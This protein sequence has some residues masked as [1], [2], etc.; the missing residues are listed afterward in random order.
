MILIMQKSVTYKDT[1]TTKPW[2]D[3]WTSRIGCFKKLERLHVRHINMNSKD[4]SFGGSFS[5]PLLF[6]FL[7]CALIFSSGTRYFHHSFY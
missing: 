7:I 4:V 5:H 6:P 1:I 2:P 3:I